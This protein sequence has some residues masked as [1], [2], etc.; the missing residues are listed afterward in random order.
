MAI[1]DDTW[2]VHAARNSTVSREIQDNTRKGNGWMVVA[3]A[4][5]IRERRVKFIR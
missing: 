5:M 4:S 2:R 3:N 1:H